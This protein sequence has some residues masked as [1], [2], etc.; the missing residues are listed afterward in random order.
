MQWTLLGGVMLVTKPHGRLKLVL[1]LM[2]PCLLHLHVSVTCCLGHSCMQPCVA[3]VD[4]KLEQYGS[5][6][7]RWFGQ[8]A[9]QHATILEVA[10]H[11]SVKPKAPTELEQTCQSA[12][13]SCEA[14]TARGGRV[15]KRSRKGGSL[16][17]VS[18]VTGDCRQATSSN[19]KR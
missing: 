7:D 17:R 11:S 3:I 1:G 13:A 10:R 8:D 9:A 16:G 19:V 14:E 15:R 12:E 5:G 18:N 6:H 4:V 2:D